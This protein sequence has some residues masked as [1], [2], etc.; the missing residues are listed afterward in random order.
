M[1]VTNGTNTVTKGIKQGSIKDFFPSPV[2]QVPDLAVK[3][4]MKLVV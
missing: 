3:E 2:K 4:R 1:L